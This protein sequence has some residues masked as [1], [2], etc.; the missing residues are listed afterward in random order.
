LRFSKNPRATEVWRDVEDDILRDLSI[1]Y[2]IDTYDEEENDIVRVTRFTPLEASLVTVPADSRVGVN[3]NHQEVKKMTDE[4]KTDGPAETETRQATPEVG[5]ELKLFSLKVERERK[6]GAKIES[7]RREDIADLFSRYED[8]YGDTF[9]DLHRACES[10]PDIS[11]D[12]AKEAIL[13]AIAE[14]FVSVDVSARQSEGS[15]FNNL[16]KFNKSPRIEAGVDQADKFSRAMET[17]LHIQ[18]GNKVD[19]AAREECRSTEWYSMSVADMA[20]NYLRMNGERAVGEK[21]QIIGQA[22]K[23]SPSHSSSHFAS[24]L[25]NVANKSM[26]D[27]FTDADETWNRW[28][29]TRSVPD[30]KATSLLNMSLFTDLDQVREGA[31][32]EYGDMS[33]LKETIQLATYGKLFG[34]TRQA[35]ANDDLNALGSVPRAMGAAANRKIGDTVYAVLTTGLSTTMLQDSTALWDAAT[36]ANYVTSGAAP[37][38][39]T[40]NAAR[41]AMATQTDPQGK[42]IGLRGR[43]LIVPIALETTAAVLMAAQYDPAGSAGTLPPN[44]FQ[45]SLMVTADHRL[46]TFNSSG[47]FVA[48]ATNQVVVGFL[49]GQQTPYMESKD[50]WSIDGIEYKVRCDVAATAED[51]RGLYY[52]DGVT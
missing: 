36:H 22:M 9:E 19:D 45:G 29:N 38:V 51:Y 52:N 17:S 3:R 37:S 18:A 49:N 33:D 5:S 16:P 26:I 42:T 47:W 20:R 11:V 24:V 21:H 6:E 1:G 41:V 13:D 27:G 46:D 43:H 2:R 15:A 44:P 4:V 48:G 31:E 35:L 28:A 14:G 40:L 8:K 7:K 10:S 30:F 32:Y 50:G 25:E 39:T 12:K 34:I 23:R